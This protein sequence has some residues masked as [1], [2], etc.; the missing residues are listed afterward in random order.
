MIVFQEYPR[1]LVRGSLQKIEDNS[2]SVVSA[3]DMQIP[4]K[5]KTVPN[6]DVTNGISFQ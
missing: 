2:I 5:K 1:F 4:L 6:I 3:A